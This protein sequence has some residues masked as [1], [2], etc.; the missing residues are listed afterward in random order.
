MREILKLTS[1][2][3]RRFPWKN[4]RGVTEELAIWPTGSSLERGDFDWRIS[5]AAVDEPG[6]FSSFPGFDRTL[7][8]TDG[9]GL[10]LEH[11]DCA[12]R[13]RLQRFEPYRFSG[14]WPTMAELP[15]GKVA[16]FN[17]L[18]RRDR[19]QASVQVL[20][21]GRRGIRE[22]L[23]PGHAFVH[24]LSGRVIARV[25]QEKPAVFGARES[26]W[27]RGL[28]EGEALDLAGRRDESVVVLVAILPAMHP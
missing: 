14:D 28:G 20:R 6:A 15:S 26:L 24:I 25:G 27:A 16:D 12:P 11:G 18:V 21:V 2:D 1:A 5:R 3:A 8:V 13:A 17:V 22:M 10:V 19:Y 23:T 4:G 9:E 7:L